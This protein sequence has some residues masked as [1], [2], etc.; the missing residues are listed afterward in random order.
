MSLG[1]RFLGTTVDKIGDMCIKDV[2]EATF[3]TPVGYLVSHETLLIMV[4]VEHEGIW[5]K[6]LIGK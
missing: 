3:T 2:P 1:T 6:Q 5:Q 4:H